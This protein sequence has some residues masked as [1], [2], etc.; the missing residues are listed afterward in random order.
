MCSKDID[1]SNIRCGECVFSSDSK[2]INGMCKRQRGEW[3]FSKSPF[4]SDQF[5]NHMICSDFE[6][7]AYLKS[8]IENEWTCFEEWFPK[9]IEEWL[10]YK[11]TDIM[12]YFNLRNEPSIRYGVKFEDFVYNTHFD[13]ENLKYVEKMYLKHT[14]NEFGYKL[15]REK[16]N[17]DKEHKTD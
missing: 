6:P 12:I 17:N 15:I 10:P 13:G 2:S 3:E 14:K 1:V 11:R 7:R 8:F 5:A 4:S 16:M 9:W